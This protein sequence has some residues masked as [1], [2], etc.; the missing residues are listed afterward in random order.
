MP[1]SA[2]TQLGSYEIL[3]AVGAGGMGEVYKARDMRLERVVAVK[4]LSAHLSGNPDLKARF[5]R[6]AKAISSL[7]HP[8]ICVQIGR[9]H[10]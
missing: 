8:H 7:Q 9:A 4:I 2:G 10:V 3:S 6:E 1:V 5:E